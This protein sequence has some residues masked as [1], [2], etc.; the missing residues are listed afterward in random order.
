MSKEV[1]KD[2]ILENKDSHSKDSLIQELEKAGYDK[3][4][5][6]EVVK[7]TYKKEQKIENKEQIKK[8]ESV[9]SFYLFIVLN[10]F[11]WFIWP[12]TLVATVMSVAAPSQSPI[13][14][15]F[16]Y[17]L[18]IFNILALPISI[19]CVIRGVLIKIKGGSNK[20]SLKFLKYPFNYAAVII[21]TIL[22][23]PIIIFGVYYAIKYLQNKSK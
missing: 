7:E 5:I 8:D 9:F 17:S 1:I 20:E 23:F 13:N 22:V 11:G 12:L 21:M 4:E 6:E 3:A 16:T 2:Y 10:I 15:I 14:M 18:Y 19:Y